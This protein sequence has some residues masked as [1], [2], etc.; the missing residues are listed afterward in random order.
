M[1]GEINR[2]GTQPS[3]EMVLLWKAAECNNALDW[4]AGL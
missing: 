4:K 1:W 3:R 2:Q